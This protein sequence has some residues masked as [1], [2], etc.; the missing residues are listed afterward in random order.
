MRTSAFFAA[1]AAFA[2]A[3]GCQVDV[4]PEELGTVRAPVL[5]DGELTAATIVHAPQSLMPVHGNR[6]TNVAA[7]HASTLERP[8]LG[9]QASF[10][11]DDRAEAPFAEASPGGRLAIDLRWD[12]MILVLGVI[13]GRSEISLE[14]AVV[15]VRDGAG[16]PVARVRLPASP[17][18]GAKIEIGLAQPVTGRSIEIEPAEGQPLSVAELEAWTLLLPGQ[19]VFT[20]P[21]PTKGVCWKQT[22]GRGAGTPIDSCAAGEEKDGALCYPRCRDGFVGEGPLCFRRCPSGFVDDGLTC[23]KPG[24]IYAKDSYG[25]G[26]GTLPDIRGRCSGDRTK[27]D[28]LCYKRCRDGYRGRGPVCWRTCDDGYRDDGAFCRRDPVIIGQESYGRGA[29][30]PLRCGGD[31]QLDGALCY[32]RCKE[33]YVGVGPVCWNDCSNQQYRVD[34]GFACASDVEYCR[35][36][37]EDATRKTIEMAIS[38]SSMVAGFYGSGAAIGTVTR[39]TGTVTA[40]ARATM[41]KQ[42]TKILL[43]QGLDLAQDVAVNAATALVTSYLDGTPF[44]WASLDP[45]GIAPVVLAFKQPIC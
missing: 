29:G 5:A 3:T 2:L 11:N 19:D 13:P 34:C 24:D 4:E 15:T 21:R 18:P 23:R 25:R 32:P 17:R 1:C 28:G 44:D 27:Q 22:Y 40:A 16:R 30:T 7:R 42:V 10:G 26:V 8:A 31:L 12:R 36:F 43:S 20:K 35:E 37:T 41:I 33:R 9:A 39:A 14:G 38:I 6:L 45:T